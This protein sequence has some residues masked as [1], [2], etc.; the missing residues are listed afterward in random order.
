MVTHNLCIDLGDQPMDMDY[1]DT[2]SEENR[3]E[4]VPGYGG[5]EVNEDVPLPEGETEE[6][7]RQEG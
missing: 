7:L 5:I 3:L 1:I 6:E 2:I 4:D